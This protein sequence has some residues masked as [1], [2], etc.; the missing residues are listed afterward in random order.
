MVYAD[1]PS[2][3]ERMENYSTNI[4]QSDVNSSGYCISKNNF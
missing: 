2:V 4:K 1:I 3:Y